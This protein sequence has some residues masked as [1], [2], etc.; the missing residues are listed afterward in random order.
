M[1]TIVAINVLNIVLSTALSQY[2]RAYKRKKMIK[3]LKGEMTMQELLWL[4][5]QPWFQ[6]AFEKV[7]V[8][9]SKKDD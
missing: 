3:W 4:K 5:R 9:P 7:K 1:E 6:R 8:E 2:E